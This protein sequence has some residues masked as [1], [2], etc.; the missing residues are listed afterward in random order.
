MPWIL[1]RYPPAMRRLLPAVCINA[2]EIAIAR[3]QRC[4]DA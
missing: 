4:A 3:E 2:I 1:D